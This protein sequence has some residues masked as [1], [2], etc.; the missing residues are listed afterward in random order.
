M[1]CPAYDSPAMKVCRWVRERGQRELRLRQ[2]LGGGTGTHIHVGELGKDLVEVGEEHDDL[3]CSGGQLS[4][5][6]VL[7]DLRE[8]SE[9]SSA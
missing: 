1:Y 7:G 2:G 5:V 4:H 9:R 6:V 3:L 8:A